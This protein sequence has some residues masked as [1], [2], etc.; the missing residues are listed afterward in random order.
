MTP[1]YIAKLDL[2]IRLT[3]I[4]TQKID[5]SILKTFEIVFAN[6]QVKDKLEKV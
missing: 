1:A 5:N 4:K 3:N 2:K 6:F